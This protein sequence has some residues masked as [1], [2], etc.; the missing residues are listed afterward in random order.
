ALLSISNWIERHETMPLLFA[1]SSA[2]ISYVFILLR[3]KNSNLLLA[4]G[5]IIRF[6]FFLSL[7][8]LS[9][10][11]YRF[12]WDGTL[13]KN[14]IHPFAELPGYYLSQGI[15]EVS[16][17]LFNRLNSPNYFTIYP[18]LNQFIFWLSAVI[19]NG[20]WLVS[21]NIIRLILYGADIGSFILLKQLLKHYGKSE[22][23]A[24]WYFL[25][26]LVILEF[27]GNLHFE[28]LVI[29]FLLLG[30]YAYEKNKKTLSG[31]GLGLAIGTKLLP[32]IFLPF[33]FLKGIKEKKWSA[34][35]LGGLIG[36][37]TLLPMLNQSFIDGMQESLDLYF[38]SFEFNASLYFIAREIGHWIYGYN[39]IAL[40]GPLL[41]IFSI[42]SILSISVFGLIKKWS[43]PKT[44]LFILT[45]YLLLATTVHPWYILPLVVFGVLSGYWYPII[46]SAMIFLTYVGYTKEGFELPMF[47]VVIEYSITGLVL[48]TEIR[49]KNRL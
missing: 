11:L 14:G 6:L 2:F 21:A 16:K 27:V 8:I 3:P 17:E 22:N 39:N 10:D 24:F 1:Y 41:S 13:L 20:D 44:L 37:L 46:W 15:P 35:I 42:L 48:L 36:I 45:T 33:F 28:G 34:A 23:L 4:S 49:I 32:L 7:P 38:R 19:G 9:D 5:V 40:I 31:I 26:P 29:F 43:V 25:N 30:V 12:I 47:I 18:P